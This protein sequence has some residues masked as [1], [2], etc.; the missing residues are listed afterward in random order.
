MLNKLNWIK[1]HKK[2]QLNPTM[3]HRFQGNP[4]FVFFS[5]N[6]LCAL[7]LFQNTCNELYP[8]LLLFYST[9]LKQTKKTD[10]VIVMFFAIVSY[11]HVQ[12]NQ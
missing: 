10:N 7:I 4:P 3:L 2:V 8:N 12:H 9:K 11:S 6:L 1:T 5:F